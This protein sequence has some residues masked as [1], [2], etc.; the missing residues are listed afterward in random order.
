MCL[1]YAKACICEKK[2]VPL[3]SELEKGMGKAAELWFRIGSYALFMLRS[4]NTMGYGIHSPYLF[5][6]ARAILPETAAYYCFKDV[7]GIRGELLRDK[8]EVSVEDFG[9][10]GV[11]KRQ[12]AKVAK[13]ALKGQREAQALF[14]LVNL[15]KAETVVE[16]G[17]SLGVTTAYLA[18]PNKGAKV[19]TFEGSKALLGIAKQNWKRLGI[20]NIESVQ[21]NIDETLVR[22]AEKWGV[23]G[24]AFMD[25]N[26]RKDATLRYFDVLAKHAGEKS[27]FAV[28]DIRYSREMW[29]AWEKIEKREDVSARM[30]LGT[31]GLVFFDKHFPKQT[32][33]IR[34]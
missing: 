16:L 29:E 32:F 5:Y 11:G 14:R 3:Q 22:E 27:I 9:V 33:R 21:G 4:R 28:D 1:F 31:M 25:A 6:I 10:G 8:T 24:F 13:V 17:T 2:I 20:E 30:D 12:V 23:V 18:L 15:V 19:W 26:H 7:E 34:L